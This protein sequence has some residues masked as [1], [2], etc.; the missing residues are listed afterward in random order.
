MARQLSLSDLPED[1]ARLAEAQ[2]ASG[3]FASVDA[4]LKAGMV[5]L[6]HVERVR[7]LREAGEAGLASL[8]EHGPQLE[9]DEE[10]DAFM[11][12]CVADALRQ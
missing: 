1:I 9:S 7:L 10:F 4:V 2:M 11:D 12:E 8:R 5:A 6:E 3:R